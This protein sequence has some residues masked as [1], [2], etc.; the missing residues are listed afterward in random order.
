MSFISTVINHRYYSDIIEAS[1]GFF[2][3]VADEIDLH[4]ITNLVKFSPNIKFKVCERFGICKGK[5]TNEIDAYFSSFKKL[6]QYSIKD[7]VSKY[8]KVPKINRVLNIYGNRKIINCDLEMKIDIDTSSMLSNLFYQVLNPYKQMSVIEREDSKLKTLTY[9]IKASFVVDGIFKEF[10]VLDVVRDMPEARVPKDGIRL[11]A[12]LVP[13]IKSVD[14]PYYVNRFMNKYDIDGIVDIDDVVDKMGLT[15]IDAFTLKPVKGN[16]IKGLVCISNGTVEVE[17]CT[18]NVHEGTILIDKS[19]KDK[20]LGSYRFVVL[21]ECVHYDLHKEFLTVR[22]QLMDINAECSNYETDTPRAIIDD[23]IK[24]DNQYSCESKVEW[25]ANNIAGRVL[26]SSEMLVSELS[27]KYEEYD[28]FNSDNKENIL[29]VIAS[30]LAELF[31]A[32]KE[33]ICIRIKQVSFFTNDIDLAPYETPTLFPEEKEEIYNTDVTFRQLID[34]NKVVYVDNRCVIN[35]N[36]YFNNGAITFYGRRHPNESM[37]F[38]KK[39]TNYDSYADDELYYVKPTK[40]LVDNINLSFKDSDLKD[41]IDEFTKLVTNESKFDDYNK[42]DLKDTLINIMKS[43]KLT[44]SAIAERTGLSKSSLNNLLNSRTSKNIYVP[45]LIVFLHT[46]GVPVGNAKRLISKAIGN[47]E[48]NYKNKIM[49]FT[50]DK[51]YSLDDFEFCEKINEMNK[52]GEAID[53]KAEELLYEE[54][55]FESLK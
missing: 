7:E 34:D 28:Y 35:N 14:L 13:A 52:A 19:L 15:I 10:K 39:N 16:R 50:M 26:V 27:K 38:F 29:R 49:E 40:K 2:L 51:Y 9:Y 8:L 23:I 53:K 46:A 48:E 47:F 21:H 41:D 4:K 42:T 36:K 31:G 3:T 37:I 33:E 12:S 22:K 6:N 44:L 32:S 43:R 20:S 11:S 5:D 24:N 25:Q 45:T 30:D 17:E 1:N 18:L 54:V 55:D